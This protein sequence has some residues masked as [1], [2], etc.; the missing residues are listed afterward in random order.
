[1]PNELII[2]R[3]IANIESYINDLKQVENITFEE[4]ETNIIKQRFIERTL[5]IIIESI[6][7]I[8]HHIISDLHLREPNSYSDAFNVLFEN[9]LISEKTRN[10]GKLMS[11]FRNRLV[12]YYE[13]NDPEVVYG[14]L[15]NHQID[16]LVF[17]EDEA[18]KVSILL[19]QSS[20][21]NHL[22]WWIVPIPL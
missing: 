17:I 18:D 8:V 10:S 14:I 1:M 12:Q 22:L 2:L 5:H 9:Q 19:V 11:Q 16:F 21:L 6:I 4:F 3:L 20:R 7:D 15:I 13:K